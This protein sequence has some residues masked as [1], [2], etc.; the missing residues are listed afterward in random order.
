MCLINVEKSYD[1]VKDKNFGIGYKA[2]EPVEGGKFESPLMGGR[3]CVGKWYKAVGDVISADD[4][5]SY[6]AG[7]HIFLNKEDAKKYALLE[8][9]VVRVRYR[10]IVAIGQNSTSFQAKGDCVIAKEMY[11]EGEVK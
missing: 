4:G 7:F 10:Q 6:K 3:H 8:D 2:M 5:T 11:I 1:N 9:R